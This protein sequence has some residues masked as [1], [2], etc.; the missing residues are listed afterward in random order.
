MGDLSS[1]SLDGRQL[2]IGLA[3]MSNLVLEL[4]LGSTG[5]CQLGLS[6]DGGTEVGGERQTDGDPHEG[7]A[8]CRVTSCS[9]GQC[10]QFYP[11]RRLAD[12]C[13]KK[14]PYGLS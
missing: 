5:F 1:R 3:A 7:M 8:D 14:K 9:P 6:A 11:N 4:G 13:A 2:L 10:G 12:Q